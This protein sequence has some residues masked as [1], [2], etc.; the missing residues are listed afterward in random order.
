MTWTHAEG[1]LVFVDLCVVTECVCVCARLSLLRR[2]FRS[3]ALPNNNL[4]FSLVEEKDQTTAAAVYDFV[5]LSLRGERSAG[6][7]G[8]S[9]AGDSL[10]ILHG[11][12]STNHSLVDHRD[13]LVFGWGVQQVKVSHRSVT[14]NIGSRL[15]GLLR[16]LITCMPGVIYESDML[17]VFHYCTSKLVLS[18]LSIG[19]FLFSPESIRIPRHT[20][21]NR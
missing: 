1:V 14:L 15:V 9:G 5:W 10:V 21:Y 3:S 4:A 19:R 17:D 11:R 2:I 20:E 6:Y 12:C 16:R 8:C 13:P 18:V 7:I